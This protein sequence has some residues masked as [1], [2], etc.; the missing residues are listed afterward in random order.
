MKVGV[1]GNAK[2]TVQMLLT[3]DIVTF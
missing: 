1:P 2:D 3:K